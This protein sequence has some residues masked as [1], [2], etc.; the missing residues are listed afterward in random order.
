MRRHRSRRVGQ[1]AALTSEA[2]NK[3]NAR[4]GCWIIMFCCGQ[5]AI[6]AY[7]NDPNKYGITN[8]CINTPFVGELKRCSVSCRGAVWRGVVCVDA[9]L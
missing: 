2:V 1:H 4:P 6:N 9:R 8:K 3:Y 5:S 7:V